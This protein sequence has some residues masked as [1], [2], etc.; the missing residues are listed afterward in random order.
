MQFVGVQFFLGFQLLG[1]AYVS[2]Y[3]SQIQIYDHPVN[4][5]RIA[6]RHFVAIYAFD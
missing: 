6:D 4:V 1:V 5:I 2:G 3:C